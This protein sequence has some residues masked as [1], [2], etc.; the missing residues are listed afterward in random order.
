MH[1]RANTP[2]ARYKSRQAIAQDVADRAGVS[3]SA[4]S[5][6]LN[7][8]AKGSISAAKQQAVLEA[9]SRL[10][11]SPNIVAQGLRTSKARIW[12]CSPG[13]PWAGCPCT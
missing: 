12:A 9:A 5:L 13:K 7:G 10:D 11:Y 2:R 1:C 3:R 6:V 8:R 4:V